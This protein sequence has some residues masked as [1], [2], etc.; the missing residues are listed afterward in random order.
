MSANLSTL[1][2]A[3]P[4]RRT[5]RP[6]Q[7]W[8]LNPVQDGLFVIGAPLVVFALAIT[9]FR[10]LGSEHAAALVIGVHIIM[11][12]SHHLPTF[13][14][15][16]GDVEL[17]R[18]FRWTILLAPVVPLMFS[19]AALSYLAYRDL[20]VENFLYLFILLVLWDPWHFLMQHY[21]FMRIYDR[22][23]AAPPKLAAR[24]DLALCASWF[25]FSMLAAGDW[26]T[27]L[28]DDLFLSTNLPLYVAVPASFVEFATRLA[29]VAALALTVV[30]TG[31]IVGCRR[32]GWFVSPAKL[33]LMVATF[34]VLYFAYTPNDWVL[35]AA[36]GWT[37]KVGFATI[38]IVH[39][40]QYLA[41]V[42]RYNRNLAQHPERSRAGWFRRLHGRGGL[43]AVA[44][45]ILVCLSYGSGLSARHEDRLMMSVMLALGFT[46]TLLH[47]YYDGFI[48][49]LREARNREH[50]QLGE[51]RTA[52]SPRLGSA[53]GRMI[54]R[55]L[56]YFGLPMALLSAGAL[57]I[58]NGA[59]VHYSGYM[60]LAQRAHERGD[61]RV[62]MAEAQ[63][64]LAAMR[65][66]LPFARRMVELQPTASRQAALALL[67]HEHARY[68]FRLL[69]QL[70][71]A[72]IDRLQY[73]QAIGEAIALL[74]AALSRGGS[75]AHPYREQMKAD[76]A[77]RLL[78]AWRR[79]LK[80]L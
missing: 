28:L 35:A 62:A 80:R 13:I 7:N 50:L 67:L 64:A 46:S 32:R 41:I 44:V 47:Y 72:E 36:P 48:W 69:P 20:P 68:A 57:S 55:Q 43:L 8:V 61:D 75:L 33:A 45:Y 40:T 3:S 23:N 26:L 78:D 30:Y 77:Y 53:P 63:Q 16:Y 76:D 71:G 56:A 18:R 34:G 70:N 1:G 9:A 15:I 21:G 29:F 59:G 19:A 12:V 22:Y 37:F 54:L 39:M 6:R 60:M 2:T 38:G 27:G 51:A 66:E 52:T 49:K 79:E 5:A 73:R 11:T 31:Y 58:W 24:M 74:E 4:A 65:R 10:V 25:L 17:M 42:W 14:R